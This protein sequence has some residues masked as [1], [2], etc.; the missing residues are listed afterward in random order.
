[1]ERNVVYTCKP[2]LQQ[3]CAQNLVKQMT[4]VMSRIM[5]FQSIV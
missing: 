3:M 1:M 5:E 4:I 2:V